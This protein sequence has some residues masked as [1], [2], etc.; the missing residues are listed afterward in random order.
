MNI[1]TEVANQL[2]NLVERLG[3]LGQDLADAKDSLRNVEDL[4][5]GAVAAYPQLSDVE[6]GLA[7]VAAELELLAEQLEA[8]ES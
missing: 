2:R 5:Y 8:D 7:Q 1:R 3:L 4:A 6:R